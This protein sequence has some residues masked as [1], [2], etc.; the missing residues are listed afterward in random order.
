MRRRDFI[1]LFG[2]AAVAWPRAA[3]AQQVRRIGVLMPLVK[4]DPEDQ[5]R[6]AALEEGLKQ[7]GWIEGRNIRIEYRWYAGEAA[8]ARI[9]AKELIDSR[10]ELIVVGSSPGT[11]AVRQET[12]TIP[13]VFV[14]VADPVGAGL[15]G[16]LVRPGG[17]ATGLT[18]FEFSVGGKLLETLKQAAPGVVR[19]AVVYNPQT[20][21]F[22]PYLSSVQSAASSF[23]VTL[24]PSPVREPAEIETAL[25]AIGR[26]L[27]GGVIC[28]P[29]TYLT[30][31]RQQIVALTARH[32]L[33]AIYSARSFATDGGLV[34]YGV[35][36]NGLYRRSAVY[37]DRILKGANPSELPVQQPTKYELVLNLKTAKA[38]GLTIPL[39]LQVGADE[40]IE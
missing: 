25:A 3:R 2:G 32:K 15:V 37:V 29:D 16:N 28:L 19:V 22:A 18:F 23:G 1:T 11:L 20:S 10:P 33:P 24:V 40:V 34:S 30:V 5:A 9:L 12:R 21:V 17:N 13:M 8:Q 36:T 31:H 6:V 27:G 14:A 35:D 7:A 4:D 39:S 26:E 38:L